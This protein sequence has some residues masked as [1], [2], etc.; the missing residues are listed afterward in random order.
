MKTHRLI[1]QSQHSL[2]SFGFDTHH[3]GIVPTVTG[4]KEEK[5]LSEMEFKIL[6][7]ELKLTAVANTLHYSRIKTLL[8]S[9]V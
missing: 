1:V 9:L 3:E 8:F 6:A 5:H 2:S 4:N 7:S